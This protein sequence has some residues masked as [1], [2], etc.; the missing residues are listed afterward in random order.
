MRVPLVPESP[1]AAGGG[2]GGRHMNKKIRDAAVRAAMRLVQVH[3]QMPSGADG[4]TRVG[5]S[6]GHLV[7]VVG[8]SHAACLNE[9]YD[10]HNASGEIEELYK[11][12]ADDAGK[13]KTTHDVTARVTRKIGQAI[14]GEDGIIAGATALT[15]AISLAREQ[16]MDRA[17]FGELVGAAWD[18]FE[19]EAAPTLK[20]ENL[21]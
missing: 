8:P 1:D 16:G 6:A 3:N 20:P 12:E 13:L 19:V 5:S 18:R 9:W 2:G 17:T 15:M 14:D 10:E 4:I 7:V 11:C 21:Q